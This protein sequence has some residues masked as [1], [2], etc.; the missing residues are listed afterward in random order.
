MTIKKYMRKQ[1][2]IFFFLFFF[3]F[4]CSISFANDSS[5]M[6]LDN[7]ISTGGGEELQ[8]SSKNGKWRTACTTESGKY[9]SSVNS[10][11]TAI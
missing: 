1:I 2:F 6:G 9:T 10:G 3:C 8:V 5:S 4:S 7:N 11:N